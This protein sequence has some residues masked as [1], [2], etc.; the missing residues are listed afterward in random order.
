LPEEI[1]LP[2]KLTKFKFTFLG[3]M[4]DTIDEV[5]VGKIFTDIIAENDCLLDH[6]YFYI[7]EFPMLED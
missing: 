2:A 1:D 5:K 7:Y 6:A 4:D 3:W